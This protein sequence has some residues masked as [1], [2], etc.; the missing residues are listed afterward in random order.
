MNAPVQLSTLTRDPEIIQSERALRAAFDIECAAASVYQGDGPPRA[1]FRSINS[2]KNHIYVSFGMGGEKPEGLLMPSSENVAK[3][4][5]S[6]IKVFRDWLQPK[7]TLVWRQRP[8]I[9]LSEDGRWASYWRCV[10]LD[11]DARNLAIDW[12]F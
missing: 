6:S 10:Q 1:L 9:E 2:E 7:R 12:H 5:S 3:V 4:L 11:D 8:L